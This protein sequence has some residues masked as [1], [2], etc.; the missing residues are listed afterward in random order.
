MPLHRSL[1]SSLLALAG[2]AVSSTTYA[3]GNQPIGSYARTCNNISVQGD[4]LSASCTKLDGNSQQTTLPQLDECLNSITRSGDIANLDGNL[5]CMPDLPKPD[6]RF[7]F[8]Q[9]ETAINQWAYDGKD[10]PEYEHGWGVWSGLTRFVGSINGTPVRAFETW[11]TP[12][13]MIYQTQSG[14]G[15]LLRAS[16]T[17]RKRPGLELALPHQFRNLPQATKQKLLRAPEP[18]A[19]ASDTRIFVSVAYNPPAAQH[20]V[21]NKLFLQSTLDQYLKQGYTE[22]PDFPSNAI[23]IKPVYKVISQNVPNGIY[24]FPGW[25]GTPSPA[26]T[27]SEADW[28]ACV[29]VDING[30]GPGGNSID[31]GCKGRN[32]TNTFNLSNFIS[33]KL[34]QAD[35][36]YLRR[37]L[38]LKTATAG[39]YA[40][41]VAMHVTTRESKRWTWQTFWWSANADQPFSPSSKA[42]ADVRPMKFLDPA[43]AH[44]AMAVAYEMVSPAQPI[45]GGKNTGAPV[46]A[47]NPHLEA[48]FDPTVFQYCASIGGNFST[49]SAANC[50]QTDPSIQRFGVQ[51]NCMSCHNLAMYNPKVDYNSNGGANRETPYS[52]DLYMSLT[53]PAFQGSLK[54]DFAWSILGSMVSEKH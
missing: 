37:E 9:S 6:P 42:I 20:A 50:K 41:L 7:V 1:S 36:E 44:Y 53:D 24:T 48:G 23:T 19:G 38:N 52:P 45:M 32:A 49:P 40:I 18:K 2:L 13:L 4:S 54:L 12:N 39:D 31:T 16:T 29:Y 17:P 27:F 10:A 15:E 34:S 25:P 5:I 33:Q 28:N 46:I 43:A 14:Q 21:S 26:K 51:T 11:S 3:A 35:A 8:P 47:Y 30:K 22:V